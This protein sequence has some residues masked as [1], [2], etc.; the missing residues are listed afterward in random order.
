MEPLIS[1]II[2]VYKVESYLR[3]CVDSVLRQ[4]YKNLEIILVDD[5]SPDN[6]GIICDEYKEKDNR[7]K[8]IHKQNGGLSD[9]RNAGLRIM[10]GSY[11]AFVDSDDW[12]ESIMYET[13][14]SNLLVYD[15]DI[16]Y[17]GVI[18]E[19]E[20]NGKTTPLRQ[21]D[22]GADAFSE[23]R[24]QAM[25]RFF[26][27]PWAAWDKLYRAELF[28]T[29]RF[30]VGEINEDEAIALHLI[31]LSRRVCYCN[32]PLYHY[33]R[34]VGSITTSTFSSS[35]LAWQRHC[36]E[37]LRFIRQNYP[38]LEHAAAK[39]YRGSLLWTLTEIA[40]QSSCE[41]YQK[42]IDEMMLELHE[43]TKQ[44]N[45]IPFEWKSDRM[46]FMILKH[47]GFQNYRR[48]LRVWR[49]V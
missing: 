30:P 24:E 36:R 22:Y 38:Q 12:I 10:T 23:S 43:N 42:D 32:K 17:G 39:R 13:L 6:C 48:I 41:E 25:L 16:S 19:I 34:R 31:D 7:I 37:N 21:S 2:P 14:L 44:F 26:N 28:Q 46:R 35:K 11:V 9:A 45:G 27:G 3:Q 47:L 20:T 18:D 5:G 1:V 4:T 29:I 8:V 15:A 40:M 49:G 33:L